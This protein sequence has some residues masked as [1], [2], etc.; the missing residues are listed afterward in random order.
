MPKKIARKRVEEAV[1]HLRKV[2]RDWLKRPGVTAVDVGYKMKDKKLTDELAIRVHV[3]RK[4]PPETLSQYELLSAKDRPETLGGFSIDV[5]EA[6]Y[7]PAVS[8]PAVTQPEAVD[9]RD[10][11]DPLIGGVSVG[12]PRITAGTLGAVVWD[13]SDAEVCIL[14]N[15]HVLCGSAACALGEAIYQPGVY[16]GG[17]AADKVAELKRWRLDRDA[18]AALA[19]LIGSRGYSRDILQLN[20]VVGIEESPTLGM[21]VIK[22]GR[23]TGVTEGI[24]DGIGLSLTIDYGGGTVQTFHD[25]LHIVPGPPW[26]GVDVEISMGGDSGSVWVN[27]DTG[28]AVGLHFAGETDPS[29]T[30]EHAV[31]NRMVQVAENLNISFVPLFRPKPIVDDRWRDAIRRILCRY[32]P[33]MCDPGRRSPLPVSSEAYSLSQVPM[34]DRSQSF[35][36]PE[37]ECVLDEIMAELERR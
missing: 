30:A 5:I 12:N 13:R 36:P 11:V 23:T 6:E 4:L 22:S 19:R 17:T 15:W 20:P 16:D 32:Y 21:N 27:K 2:R 25:Q 10:R 1:A 26:P 3:R 35:T 28:K 8:S 37:I 34:A 31:A 29:P 24:I 33:W 18:D 7:G 14:S 9:R